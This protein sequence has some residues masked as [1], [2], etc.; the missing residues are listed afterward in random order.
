LEARW[1]TH[2]TGGRSAGETPSRVHTFYGG[3]NLIRF[4]LTPITRLA[5][6]ERALREIPPL[7]HYVSQLMRQQVPTHA[8]SRHVLLHRKSD[9]FAHRIRQ[10]IHCPCRFGRPCIRVDADAAEVVAEAGL[11]E[12]AGG[13]VERLAGRAQYFVHDGRHFS[14]F[15]R[16]VRSPLQELLLP[17]ALALSRQP[18]RASARTFPL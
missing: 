13:G 3:R 11:E 8:C 7:L 15:R 9:I 17:A 6:A 1:S 12:G 4:P 5:Y 18:R 14:W 2:C 16:A 10:R